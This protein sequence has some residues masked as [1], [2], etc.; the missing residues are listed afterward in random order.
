[1][2]TTMYWTL[3]HIRQAARELRFR[4]SCWWLGQQVE[5]LDWRLRLD[6]TVLSVRSLQALSSVR[7]AECQPVQS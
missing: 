2:T 4:A 6:A 1:M 7:G 3:Q 5:F